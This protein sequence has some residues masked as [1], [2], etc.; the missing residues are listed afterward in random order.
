MNWLKRKILGTLTVNEL[1]I[2][3]A[4]MGITLDFKFERKN[5]LRYYAKNSRLWR[6]K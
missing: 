2:Y 5:K 6:I 1:Y 3:F 4:E